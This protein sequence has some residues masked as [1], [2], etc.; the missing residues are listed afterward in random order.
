MDSITHLFYGGVI[1][2]AIAPRAHRRAALLAGMALNTLPDLD[3]LPLKLFGDPVAQMTWHRGPTHSLLLLPLLA[4]A[5]W[6][7]FRRRGGR[8]ATAPRRWF[9]VFMLT[10]LAHPLLDA[11]TVY[12]TQLLWPL[13]LAPTMWSSLFIIDPLFLL[14]WLL[15]CVVALWV[16]ARRIADRALVAGLVLGFGYLA[17][18]LIAKSM[19]DRAADQALAAIGL[20]DAPRFSV[21]MPFNT[22]LWRV[23][24][25]TPDGYLE[26]ER[27]VVADRGPMHFRAYAE[28]RAAR[29]ALARI[30][31]AARLLW[32]NHHFAKAEVREDKLL[33]TDLRMGAEPDYT[34]RFVV[35]ERVT[36]SVNTAQGPKPATDWRAVRPEQLTWP[37]DAAHRLPALWA[38]T[39]NGQA[40]LAEEHP[41]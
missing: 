3:V 23:V 17:W 26:G 33:L 11:F 13:P 24:V 29:D 31:A 20:Q 16:P 27:S 9:W 18:S 28:D 21:P 35:A 12:G 8:V 10:L 5:L 30:P 32:F 19:V 4:W 37:W 41:E 40:A 38:R 6:A 15:A 2:A 22:L 14:P 1:A 36:A 39:W 25:M 34:F 7:W